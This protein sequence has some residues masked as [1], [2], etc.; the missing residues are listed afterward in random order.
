MNFRGAPVKKNTLYNIILL[1]WPNVGLVIVD[2][3][4]M[5]GKGRAPNQE[6]IDDFLQRSNWL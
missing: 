3:V 4:W 1:A 6:L 2:A 5:E